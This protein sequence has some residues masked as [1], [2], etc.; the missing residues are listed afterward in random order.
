MDNH[1]AQ[2]ARIDKPS[3]ERFHEEFV[4]RGRPVILT[5][6]ASEWPARSRWSPEFFANHFGSTPVEVEV[7]RERDPTK[8]FNEKE[9]IQTT[10]A[11]YVELLPSESPKYYLNFASVMKRLPRLHQDVGSLDA[12]QPYHRDYPALVRRKMTLEPIFWFGPAGAFTPLHRDPN[13]NLL[14]QITGRKRLVL[15]SPEDTAN[16]YSPWH[17]NCTPRRCLGG[18][19]PVDVDHPDLTRFPRYRQARGMEAILHPGE[20]LFIP[21]YWWHHVTSLDVSIAVSYW[22][23][24][25]LSNWHWSTAAWSSLP[26]AL[27]C[28]VRQL[29]SG[30]GLRR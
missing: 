13:D 16:L 25:R 21:I 15:F 6:I 18:Y 22:W 26:A 5:G 9:V 8:H 29:R 27:R 12:Y 19:S 17:E 14:A 20:I 7:Q 30:E 24:H 2:V 3:P 28:R 23:F 10:L 4:R 1:L 11:R